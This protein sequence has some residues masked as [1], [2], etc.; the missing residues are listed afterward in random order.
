MT[1]QIN[2]SN[3][4][5]MCKDFCKLT[6]PHDDCIPERF[7]LF[8][9]T[10]KNILKCK[11]EYTDDHAFI[12]WTDDCDHCKTPTTY[13]TKGGIEIKH[14]EK[15]RIVGNIITTYRKY[16]CTTTLPL[17]YRT[18][19]CTKPVGHRGGCS[20]NCYP[21]GDNRVYYPLTGYVMDGNKECSADMSYMRTLRKNTRTLRVMPGRP[22]I[23]DFDSDIPKFIHPETKTEFLSQ[24]D[25]SDLNPYQPSTSPIMTNEIVTVKRK[26]TQPTIPELVNPPSK[27][28]RFISGLQKT[29]DEY[30]TT[31]LDDLEEKQQHY[32]IYLYYMEQEVLGKTQTIN[33]YVGQTRQDIQKRDYDH[34]TS[35]DT[36]FDRTLQ[37]PSHYLAKY[38]ILEEKDTVPDEDGRCAWADEMEWYYICKYHT[39]RADPDNPHGLNTAKAPRFKSSMTKWGND[40]LELTQKRR[41][42]ETALKLM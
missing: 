40:I 23:V 36:E 30:I 20:R 17:C 35:G 6:L 26:F 16:T 37:S 8:Y 25:F 11:W 19:H 41:I 12:I 27:R 31:N 2:G 9:F 29:I 1:Q 3:N 42:L 14:G 22:I 4:P 33:L 34:R 38:R 24:M 32:V 10:D 21:L 28:S 5:K 15:L 7:P 39:L 18:W 13:F